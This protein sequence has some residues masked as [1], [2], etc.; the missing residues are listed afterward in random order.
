MANKTNWGRGGSVAAQAITSLS[1]FDERL[2][3]PCAA[4]ALTAA[5]TARSN[6]DN[7]TASRALV[8]VHLNA[9]R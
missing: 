7:V 2:C 4:V 1:G 6:Y 8:Q 5:R 9:L 3:V